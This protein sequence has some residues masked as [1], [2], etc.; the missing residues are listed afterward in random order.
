[1]LANLLQIIIRTASISCSNEYLFGIPPLF[2]CMTCSMNSNTICYLGMLL[3][4]PW[5]RHSTCHSEGGVASLNLVYKLMRTYVAVAV[6]G[7]RVC[8]KTFLGSLN[9][10][11]TIINS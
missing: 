11:Y 5:Y 7:S 10:S 8:P 1:M 2:F 9:L 6:V 4:Q 3:S